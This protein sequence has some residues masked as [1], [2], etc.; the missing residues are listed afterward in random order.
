[1]AQAT[2][3]VE[4]PKVEV[5]KP[6]VPPTQTIEPKPK[7][8]L[9][10]EHSKVDA[11]PQ[12]VPQSVPQPASTQNTQPETKV[13]KQDTPQVESPKANEE[14][15]IDDGQEILY[16]RNHPNAELKYIILDRDMD[17]Y[18]LSKKY[19]IRQSALRFYNDLK[20]D[21]L[22]RNQIIFLEEKKSYGSQATHKTRRGETMYDISQRYGIKLSYLYIK[23]RMQEGEEP[24]EGQ[25]IYLQKRK[26]RR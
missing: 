13:E 16:V 19:G 4:Q 11:K 2:K 20:T 7:E 5:T 21:E 26:P 17:L 3:P 24:K 10:I 9:K 22:K 1:M 25:V 6:Q 14:E 18:L 8:E 15:N 23:N 12:P